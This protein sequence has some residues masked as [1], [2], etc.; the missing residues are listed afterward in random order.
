M[1]PT[2]P[3]TVWL[4]VL[5]P[6]I[7]R[8]I[9]LSSRCQNQSLHLFPQ[10]NK[11]ETSPPS[12]ILPCI[13]VLN[14]NHICSP[15]PKK[16]ELLSI[17]GTIVGETPRWQQNRLQRQ[18]WLM[19]FSSLLKR[20]RDGVTSWRFLLYQRFSLCPST[21]IHK[22]EKQRSAASGGGTLSLAAQ[23]SIFLLGP[24]VDVSSP[25]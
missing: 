2:T 17:R 23:K 14:I 9:F 7:Q 25:E 8:I 10:K 20:Q 24:A 18:P 5:H 22:S 15:I 4:Q 21:L 11:N 6:F 19:H 16:Q 12:K 1:Y 13:K 3:G